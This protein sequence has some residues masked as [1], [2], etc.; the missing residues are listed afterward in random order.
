MGNC[1][2]NSNFFKENISKENFPVTF[3]DK[4]GEF[5]FNRLNTCKNPFK[6]T[7]LLSLWFSS[8]NWQNIKS[9]YLNW[10]KD[11]KWA[12]ILR[13]DLTCHSYHQCPHICLIHNICTIFNKTLK[14]ES[15]FQLWNC[16]FL[17]QLCMHHKLYYF[18]RQKFYKSIQFKTIQYPSKSVWE[19]ATIYFFWCCL[20]GHRR[21]LLLILTLRE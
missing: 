1:A 15:N 16:C 4:L 12:K 3:L 10:N 18:S 17:A 13:P 7:H 11:I 21:Y 9:S 6:F 8:L 5:S 19:S 20:Q 14:S 2:T